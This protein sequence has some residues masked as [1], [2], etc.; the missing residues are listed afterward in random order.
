M[1]KSKQS[2]AKV[3]TTP[4]SGKKGDLAYLARCTVQSADSA[5]ARDL[6][7]PF[8]TQAEASRARAQQDVKDIYTK[9]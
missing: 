7:A 4:K 8:L 9:K 6:P 5:Q 1:G 2:K 3:E